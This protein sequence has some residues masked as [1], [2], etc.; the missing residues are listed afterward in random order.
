[1]KLITDI[2]LKRESPEI[3][4]QS[5][6][7]L[8][9][10]C[11]SE[12]I[13]NKLDY[14]QFQILSNPFGNLYHP[15]AIETLVERS[16]LGKRY[17][18][19][20]LFFLNEAWHCFDAHS[21]LSDPDKEKLLKNLN[22]TLEIT[23][24]QINRS[25]HIIITLGTAW[26]YRHHQKDQIVA[27]CHKVPQKEF[28]KVLLSTEEV[29]ASLDKMV[30][31]IKE[32]NSGA[33]IIF[34]VSPVRHLKDGILENTRSK[35]HLVAALHEIAEREQLFYFPSFEIVLDELRDYRFYGRDLVHPNELAIDYVWDR[36]KSTWIN[37]NAYAVMETVSD[38]QKGLQH[39]PF[40]PK[41]AQH[42]QF[43]KDLRA[44]IKDLQIA[45]PF[46]KFRES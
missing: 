42:E 20:E 22:N 36:F 46:M 25:T 6:V 31:L 7:V 37:Q 30:S 1:M 2:P 16:L 13:A 45:Y 33:C 15:S 18:E 41:S 34:T 9:G 5:K 39:R 21:D 12:H 17:S 23:N 8:L 32:I 29:M 43:L 11:F 10:S 4:Y 27:N 24:R 28:D 40:N 26:A 3:D 14:H 44:R 38:L 35:A 19:N